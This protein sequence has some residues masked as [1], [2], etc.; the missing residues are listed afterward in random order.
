MFASL[1]VRV[2]FQGTTHKINAIDEAADRI[3]KY[4]SWLATRTIVRIKSRE[5]TACVSQTST[6]IIIFAA[7]VAA[8]S[9]AEPLLLL[10]PCHLHWLKWISWRLFIS[11]IKCLSGN[12]PVANRGENKNMLF[13]WGLQ[14]NN[15]ISLR[16]LC[17][18]IVS[19]TFTPYLCHVYLR[20][21]KP[22]ADC[23]VIIVALLLLWLLCYFVMICLIKEKLLDK[24]TSVSSV[25]ML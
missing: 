16:K 7:G 21:M 14:G 6:K 17:A 15:F 19:L 23:Y 2:F 18:R 1:Y 10:Y 20:M 5:F 3:Q 13:M 22:S 24:A 11:T 4:I 9:A 25:I 8:A 12:K